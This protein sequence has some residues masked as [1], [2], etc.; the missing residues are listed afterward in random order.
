MSRDSGR[1]LIA[2]ALAP[3]ALALAPVAAHAAAPTCSSPSVGV[4]HN[5]ALP[6]FLCSDPDGSVSISITT[7]PAH[8]KLLPETR[9]GW[10]TY[11]PDSGYSGPD[12]IEYSGAEGGESATGMALIE[13]AAGPK[14]VCGYRAES[15]PR[16]TPT[17]LS[18][19]CSTGGDPVLEYSI[20][21]PDQEGS[22]SRLDTD[23]GKVTYRSQPRFS[24]LESFTFSVRTSSGISD[25]GTF[26]LT[27][28]NPQQGPTG[29][30]GATGPAGPE[31][32]KGA[33]G[34][35]GPEGAKGATGPAGPEGP[36]GLPGPIGPVG[37]NGAA[38]AIGATGPQG[39]TGPPGRN[40][41][42]GAVISRD[43]LI[44]ATFM[45]APAVKS[46]RAVVLRYVSTT[47][48]G[49]VLDVSKGSRRL[50]SVKGS[51]KPGSNAIRWNGKV[52]PSSAPSGVY[53]LVLK[54]TAGAQQATDRA[55]VRITG[56]A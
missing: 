41:T 54:A 42:D 55:S 23:L 11:V 14:P 13:V 7:A 48:A 17:P 38:G 18:L 19:Q 6:M 5:A 26:D 2:L 12:L 29:A 56:R 47:A 51:A 43:R 25:T 37:P 45:D 20:G 34:P 31:G 35:A 4:P 22:L 16:D 21:I 28:L 8:G 10:R 3:A 32:A 1:R 44:V 46:G 40:G 24:G 39:P 27:V 49:V 30:T 36:Q 15:V 50:A 53:S 52:G 33:T 9:S